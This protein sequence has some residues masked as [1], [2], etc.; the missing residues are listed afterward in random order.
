MVGLRVP[1]NSDGFHT[2]AAVT[3]ASALLIAFLV[4][5]FALPAQAAGSP[6]QRSTY[7]DGSDSAG[8]VVGSTPKLDL[9]VSMTAEAWIYREDASK[10]ET[11]VGRNFKSSYWLGVCGGALRFYRS[12][13]TFADADV[14]IGQENWVHVAASYDGTD[15]EFFVDGE[16]AGKKPLSNT[17]SGKTEILRIGSEGSTFNFTGY[18]DEVRIWR[19]TRSKAQIQANMLREVT[20]SPPT[21][22]Y[23]QPEGGLVSANRGRIFGIL[24]RELTI[25]TTAMPTMTIDGRVNL[26]DEY[27]G[28]EQQVIRYGNNAGVADAVAYFVYRNYGGNVLLDIPPVKN[29]YVGV[30]NV[31]DTTGGWALADSW[32]SLHIDRDRSRDAL[33]QAEDFQVQLPLD[34]PSG[35][36]PMRWKW[37]NGAGSYVSGMTPVPSSA[38]NAW[39]HARGDLSPPDLELRINANLFP[40]AWDP[41]GLAVGHYWIGGVG[42]DRLGPSDAVWNSPATWTP[43]EFGDNAVRLPRAHLQGTVR[44]RLPDGT[45]ALLSGQTLTL[46]YPNLGGEVIAT[47]VT[48]EYGTFSFNE[49]VAANEPLEIELTPCSNCFFVRHTKHATGVIEA[50]SLDDWSVTFPGCTGGD[51]EYIGYGFIVRTP[52]EAVTLTSFEPLVGSPRVTT[53]DAPRKDLPP[54]IVTIRGNNLHPYTR[55]YLYGCLE[56]PPG[57]VCREG[58]DYWEA[59][60]VD[61]DPAERWIKV[62]V[63]EIPRSR[64]ARLKSWAVRD[65]WSRAGRQEWTRIGSSTDGFRVSR[66]AYPLL[67]GFEFDNEFWDPGAQEFY[68]VFGYNALTN[69]DFLIPVPDPIYAIVALG[70]YE[71]VMGG[72][73]GS[74]YG[75]AATSQLFFHG[76]LA[77]ADYQSGVHNAFGFTG[78]DWTRFPMDYGSGFGKGSKEET[79][80]TV[81]SGS[82]TMAV[83]DDLEM[84]EWMVGSL[85]EFEGGASAR[86]DAI[87]DINT[88]TLDRSLTPGID[89][90]RILIG[91]IQSKQSAGATATVLGGS[92]TIQIDGGGSFFDPG[93]AGERIR[94]ADG[95]EGVI[96]SIVSPSEAVL[97]APTPS[98][99]DITGETFAISTASLPP[100]PPVWSGGLFSSTPANVGALIRKNHGVQFSNEVVSEML[101]QISGYDL[102][103]EFGSSIEGDPVAVLNRLRSNPTHFVLSLVKKLG[104]GHA[105]TPYSVLPETEGATGTYDSQ[106]WRV[107]V[108]D[109]NH[110]ENAEKFVR[111]NTVTNAFEYNKGRDG[112]PDIWTGKGIVTT[113]LNVWREER[114]LPA[115][116]GNLP[117]L[118]LLTFGDADA[119]YTDDADGE[120]GWSEDGTVVDDLPG[121]KSITPAGEVR[122][123]TRA[124]LLFPDEDNPV[125]EVDINVRGANHS[126][127]AADDG[128]VFRLNFVDGTANGKNSIGLN[129]ADGSLNEVSLGDLSGATMLEGQMVIWDTVELKGG[130]LYRVLPHGLP[131]NPQWDIGV[132]RERGRLTFKQNSSDPILFDLEVM[133]VDREN[134]TIRVGMMPDLVLPPGI[135][136]SFF[137]APSGGEPSLFGAIDAD[138]D[139][140]DDSPPLSM[141]TLSADATPHLPEI[142]V[143]KTAEGVQLTWPVTP[144][145]LTLETSQTLEAGDWTPVQ[146]TPTVADGMNT[147]VA[148]PIDSK[149]FFRLKLDPAN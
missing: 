113:P 97:S 63:P 137:V 146:Q 71:G 88:A 31:R 90:A 147:T 44:E 112:D 126:F 99:P 33:A 65:D 58:E 11:I 13:R 135:T 74:C 104:I 68:S 18:I 136:Q 79:R 14:T 96:S 132:D 51:C 116:F 10:C 37:G 142:E 148:P 140:N 93:M 60:V 81:A 4:G 26:G 89:N 20:D 35:P 38:E 91:R 111:I 2:H 138:Q 72:V 8:V 119:H 120:W 15:V 115:F 134:E 32:V 131:E 124:V 21:L 36:T 107:Y 117:R 95:Y 102:T 41:I 67:H 55:V 57:P 70:V 83:S 27:A 50:T 122:S 3:G 40:D 139:G 62:Q 17:G 92:T 103:S 22:I 128:V 145:P 53:I 52:P 78:K 101:H 98:V 125:T 82:S 66:P 141:L 12:G 144:F 23:R 130:I 87:V 1:N 29:L 9:S 54:D 123:E 48:S 59:T 30:R 7:F 149:V 61:R 86:I 6:P 76:D 110:P 43:T 114:H 84:L 39:F 46:N 16:P 24:P 19:S 121:A 42:Q 56:F 106:W 25:P 85:V 143:M 133:K 47:T 129:S 28:A 94:F 64:Y 49:I 45:H 73:A 5:L 108:Y 127:L 69:P 80:A 118:A 100:F 75:M 109:N 77:Y 105:V 34:G